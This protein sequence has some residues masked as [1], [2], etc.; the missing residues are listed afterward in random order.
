VILD[1][2]AVVAV[3]RAEPPSSRILQRIFIDPSCRISAANLFESY[4]V[5]DRSGVP[6]AAEELA[7]FLDSVRPVVEPVTRD[8]ANLA[9]I[10]FHR[11][12]K[13]SG[14]S[15]RL[16]FGD[17]FAYALARFYDE[18]LLFIGNDFAATDIEPA[19]PS[20]NR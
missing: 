6:E 8:Q 14:H 15:A 19:L 9:R 17:S 10:A 11:F 18:P 12:G 13:G 5:I 7:E 3:V 16:N 2:S 4:M 1:T 20:S